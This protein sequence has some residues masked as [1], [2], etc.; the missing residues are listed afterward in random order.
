MKKTYT[1]ERIKYLNKKI[2]ESNRKRILEERKLSWARLA[3]CASILF[4]IVGISGL[5]VGNPIGIGILALSIEVGCFSY[6]E[7]K[8]YIEQAN[9][10]IEEN[11]HL[12]KIKFSCK[13][14]EDSNKERI[15]KLI[16]LCSDQK[17]TERKL[18]DAKTIEWLSYIVTTI[19]VGSVFINPATMWLP[20]VGIV[21]NVLAG[22][23][24]L[25]KVKENEKIISQTI[26]VEN[27]IDLIRHLEL[28]K[29]EEQELEELRQESIKRI[30]KCFEENGIVIREVSEEEMA[31]IE[32]CIN[33]INEL[34]EK[35]LDVPKTYSKKKKGK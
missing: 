13:K 18:D 2:V 17:Q 33:S 5:T 35:Y 10:F 21:G 12:H 34:E 11:N 20:I 32:D 7:N 4:S 25:Q 16:K 1:P 19:G 3:F 27:E 6:I 23:N 22:V 26:N 24:K 31:F 14:D 30:E 28:K 15:N 9:K 8:K 29:E